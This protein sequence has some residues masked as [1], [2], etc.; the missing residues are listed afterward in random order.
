MRYTIGMALPVAILASS[1]QSTVDTNAK[2]AEIVEARHAATV[3]VR[4]RGEPRAVVRVGQQTLASDLQGEWYDAGY[5][6]LG[7]LPEVALSS[8]GVYVMTADVYVAR[9]REQ[10]AVAQRSRLW[11]LEDGEEQQVVFETRDMIFGSFVPLDDGYCLA[12]RYDASAMDG[13][14]YGTALL[15]FADGTMGNVSLTGFESARLLL[16][17]P[18]DQVPIVLGQRRAGDGYE[19]GLFR[20]EGVE[21]RPALWESRVVAPSFNSDGTQF[22]YA[23]KSDREAARS[24]RQLTEGPFDRITTVDRTTG[25]GRHLDTE[26]DV[27]ATAFDPHEKRYLYALGKLPGHADR[28]EFLVIDLEGE[29]LEVLSREAFP[30]LAERPGW[31]KRIPE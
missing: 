10:P 26:L 29:H 30:P 12:V 31:R 24:G 13:R 20:L 3:Q 4:R 17:D 5:A 21:R 9:T 11:F 1:C 18:A 14:R 7:S 27:I 8:D 2:V 6:E 25:A 19:W 28:W 16:I 22:T 15:R 23:W